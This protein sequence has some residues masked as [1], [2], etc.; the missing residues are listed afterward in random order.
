MADAE[1]VARC[2]MRD[3]L[4]PGRGRRGVHSRYIC[5]CPVVLIKRDPAFAAHSQVEAS[6]NER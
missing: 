5:S 1:A 4:R 3:G 2:A 6:E